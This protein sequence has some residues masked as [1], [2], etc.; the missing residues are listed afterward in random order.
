MRARRRGDADRTGLVGRPAGAIGPVAM[1]LNGRAHRSGSQK[2]RGDHARDD[3]GFDPGPREDTGSCQDQPLDGRLGVRPTA[4]GRPVDGPRRSPG[5]AADRGGRGLLPVDDVL[6]QPWQHLLGPSDQ[7]VAGAPL[8]V[9]IPERLPVPVSV[10]VRRN[11]GQQDLALWPAGA[12]DG[13]TFEGI[14][15]KTLPVPPLT[16]VSGS[17]SGT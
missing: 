17:T 14:A 16:S 13:S 5:V 3:D 11:Q 12:S 8:S 7:V 4:E 1:V 6:P 2:V 10:R 15:M 9:T